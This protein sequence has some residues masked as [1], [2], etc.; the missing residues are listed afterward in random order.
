[1][2]QYE[3]VPIVELDTQRQLEN[4]RRFEEASEQVEIMVKELKP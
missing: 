1:M 4:L 2:N 3:P